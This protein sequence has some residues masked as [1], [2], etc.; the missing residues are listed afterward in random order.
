MSGEQGGQQVQGTMEIVLPDKVHMTLKGLVGP[1]A[2]E[3]IAIGT[4]M[5]MKLGDAGWQKLPN[6][7]AMGG[8]SSITNPET[9]ARELVSPTA[10]VTRAGTETVHGE[11]CQVYQVQ[12]QGKQQSLCVG[13]DNLLRRGVSEGLTID[14]YDYDAPIEVSAP[15]P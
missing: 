1:E 7:T 2:I 4:T 8:L 15:I 13:K 3:A 10:V 12:D 5:Y 14:F 11:P 6:S 9:F